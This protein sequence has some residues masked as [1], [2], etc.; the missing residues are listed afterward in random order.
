M[1]GCFSGQAAKEVERQPSVHSKVA[2]PA[3]SLVTK[4]DIQPDSP[5][6][7]VPVVVEVPGK[8][9]RWRRIRWRRGE[10]KLAVNR[11]SNLCVGAIL[12]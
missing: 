6:S 11:V 2:P 10:F 5:G 12:S 1:G 4:E 7:E 9:G 3:V 8:P